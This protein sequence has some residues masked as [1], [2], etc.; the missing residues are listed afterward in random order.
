MQAHAVKVAVVGAGITGLAAGYEAAQAG[1]EVVVYEATKRAGGRLLTTELA[2][3]PVDEGADSFLARVPWATKLCQDLGLEAEIVT[4][5]QQTAFVYSR[6]ALRALPQPN[7][8]GVPLDFDALAVSGIISSNGVHRACQEPDLAGS[9]LIGDESIGK[10]IRKRLGDELAD[11]LVDPLIGGIN[12]SSIDHLSIWAAA[13][14][15]AEAASRGHSLV[16]ELRRLAASSTTNPAQ[17]VFFSLRN[18]LGRLTDELANRLGDRLHLLSPVIKLNDLDADR[19]ILALPSDTTS[20]LVTTVSTTA[21]DL[22]RR[23]DYASVALVS[24]AFDAS[25]VNH[26]MAGSGYLVPATEG[27][28]ITACSWASSKWSHIGSAN[29]VVMRVSTGRYTDDRAMLMDDDD[30]LAAIQA[31][32]ATTMGLDVKPHTVRFS[33]WKRSLPQ[34]RPGHLELIADIEQTLARDVPWLQVTGGWAR[35]LGVATCIHQGQQAARA[36]MSQ[37][38]LAR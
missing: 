29:T 17:P 24:L 19:V 38:K 34:Y 36:S 23:I 4:P 26:P 16:R 30:L 28:T 21:A 7:V 35:G 5:A 6:G 15:L 32:L 1:A 10:L 25:K 37:N 31:D 22:L 18:G 11:Q 9:P 20:T 8:L 27:L 3:Q 14:Q 13:P 2:G 33:R 12:A